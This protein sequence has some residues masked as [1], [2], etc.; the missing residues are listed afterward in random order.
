MNDLETN[1]RPER[2]IETFEAVQFVFLKALAL[3]YLIAFLSFGTQA[4]GLIGEHGILPLEPYLRNAASV[5]GASRWRILPTLFWFDSSD[6][7]LKLVCF[8]GGV[9]AV[10]VFVGKFWR[11]ALV[12]CY[13]FYLSVV[14]AGQDFTSYQ[15][16]MLLLEVGFLAIF[17]G[18]HPLVL[19]LFRWLLFRLM[20]LSGL[21]KLMSGD[22]TWRNLTALRYHYETQPLPTPL[23]WYANLLP[24][25]MQRASVAAMFTIELLIP[26]LL[27]LPRRWRASG[28]LAIAALQV[29][30]LLTGNYTF[31]NW[32]TLALCLFAFDDDTVLRWIPR[33]IIPLIRPVE[34]GP[35]TRPIGAAA[36]AI[37]LGLSLILL[38]SSVAGRTWRPATEIVR[39]TSPFGIANNYGLFAVMTTTR[40]EIILEGSNDGA[41]WLA[42]EFPYK[43]GDVYRMPPVIAPLQPRLDWQMW[44]AALG[45]YR[46]NPWFVNLA[47]RL[48]QGRREVTRLLAKN[49][50]PDAP[51]R[52]IRANIYRYWFTGFKTRS[53]TGAWWNRTPRGVYMRAISLDDVRAEGM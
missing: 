10:L 48:L 5:L 18:W 1:V 50:F 13:I 8:L 40:D 44:F 24:A 38:V 22:P 9:S 29:M 14:H 20:L 25:G 42:Y 11:I 47:V 52:F 53:Q 16:D 17:T 12:F 6:A 45:T 28:G 46:N 15:W 30:I 7:F 37:V 49:P 41:K 36:G 34:P 21:A 27:F 26:F 2:H 3:V 4:T 19:G 32:L 51:P 39:L 23:A 43:P 31:F 35:I 33:R